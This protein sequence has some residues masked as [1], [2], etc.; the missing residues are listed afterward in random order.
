ML[1]STRPVIVEITQ[2]QYNSLSEAD[3]MNG[4]IYFITDAAPYSP[5]DGLVATNVG[6]NRS[7]Y[8]A[9]SL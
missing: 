7:S 2:A 8:T 1:Y 6:V 9:E 5:S 4:T 3:K